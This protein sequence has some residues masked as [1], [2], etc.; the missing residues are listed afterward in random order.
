MGEGYELCYFDGLN[1]FYVA[2]E[3]RHLRNLINVPA[4]V[5]DRFDPYRLIESKQKLNQALDDIVD[6]KRQLIECKRELD[7]PD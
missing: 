3:T 1:E 7:R 5:F 6:L 4:N 2:Q